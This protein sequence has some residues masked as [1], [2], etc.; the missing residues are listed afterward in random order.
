M[1]RNIVAEAEGARAEFLAE[2][3]A[4]D[5]SDEDDEEEEE[6]KKEDRQKTR[7]RIQV[8]RALS[9]FLTPPARPPRD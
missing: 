5:E 6:E 4:F 2:C 7:N 3:H 9:L 8:R 1:S